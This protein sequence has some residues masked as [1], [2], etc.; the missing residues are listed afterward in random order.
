MKWST[1]FLFALALAVFGAVAAM[2]GRQSARTPEEYFRSVRDKVEAGQFDEE[3]AL[4]NLDLALERAEHAKDAHLASEVRLARAKVLTKIGSWDRAKADVESV[5]AER[6]NPRDIETLL[7]DLDARSGDVPKALAR[8]ESILSRAPD[9]LDAWARA[10]ALHTEAARAALTRALRVCDHGLVPHDAETAHAL[11]ERLGALDPTD[12]QRVV[13]GHHVRALF[14]AQQGEEVEQVLAACDEAARSSRAAREALAR[15]LENGVDPRAFALLVQLLDRAGHDEEAAS[16]VAVAQRHTAVR[17]DLECATTGLRTLSELERWRFASEISNGWLNRKALAPPEFFAMACR[18]LRKSER[19]SP[20]G[21]A[22][23]EL[24]EVADTG[25]VSWSD[26][27]MGLAYVKQSAIGR[28]L[29][30]QGRLMLVSRFLPSTDAEPE[31]GT[32]A[33]AYREAALASRF[34]GEANAEREYLKGA[35]DLDPDSDGELWLR[36]AELQYQSPNAGYRDPEARWARGMSLL[37]ARTAELLPRWREFGELELRGAGIDPYARRAEAASRDIWTPPTDASPYELYRMAEV[38]IE[39][40]DTPRATLL[41]RKLSESVPGFLP[42]IDMAIEL[43]RR[44]GRTRDLVEQCVRRVRAVGGTD[45]IAALLRPIPPG[46]LTS[47]EELALMRGD[48]ERFGRV[49][50]ARTLVAR[51]ERERARAILLELAPETMSFDARVLLAELHVELEDPRAA[52]EVLGA[53]GGKV[54]DDRSALQ[55]FVRAALRANDLDRLSR[56][57]EA[58]A[59]RGDSPRPVRLALADQLLLSGQRGFAQRLLEDLDAAPETRG[60]DVV[61]RLAL[62]ALLAKDE[63]GAAQYLERAQA[64]E[65]AGGVEL[66][67][68]LRAVD[69]ADWDRA[70][71]WSNALAESRFRATPL[72][73]TLIALLSDHLDEAATTI[74]EALA[75]E[76]RATNWRLAEAVL[77]ALKKESWDAPPY[78]GNTVLAETDRFLRGADGSADPRF[79]AAALLAS[80]TPVGGGWARVRVEATTK[81]ARGT[82]W[83][84][85]MLAQLARAQDDAARVREQLAL[86]LAQHPM[87]GPAWD[88]LERVEPP[89]SISPELA[90]AEVRQRRLAA[91]G[92]LSG[93][94][95]ERLLDEARARFAKGEDALALVRQAVELAPNSAAAQSELALRLASGPDVAGALAAQ[96]KAFAAFKAYSDRDALPRHLALLARAGELVT[97]AE[98]ATELEAL[99]AAHPHDPRAVAALAR[100]DLSRDPNNPSIGVARALARL[101]TFRAQHEDRALERLAPG[102]LAAFADLLLEI[103]PVE[104]RA[105]LEAELRLEPGSPE[106]WLASARALAAQGKIAEALDELRIV[107]RLAPAGGVQREMLRWMARREQKPER[108]NLTMQAVLQAEDRTEPDPEL[109]LLRAEAQWNFG[110][111]SAQ[112]VIDLLDTIDVAK[113]VEPGLAERHA[114]LLAA[115][116]CARGEPADLERARQTVAAWKDRVGDPYRRALLRTVAGLARPD[117]AQP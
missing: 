25:R 80:T 46:T 9:D 115:A 86:L 42:A 44:E 93:P 98:R 99:A 79:A 15:T 7:V 36:L 73:R 104:A 92:T 13:L 81:R 28:E 83:K 68:L 77:A 100:E 71:S 91:M 26:F 105:T 70:A 30:A 78:F 23:G 95:P 47:R 37:P 8:I 21:I 35:L 32:R 49:V 88:Q 20:L 111:R 75:K 50:V 10:G 27:Y 112:A 57:L 17:T 65:T 33:L 85:W 14:D 11:C 97:P 96:R 101:R 89:P 16:L 67:E 40:G 106:A 84:S 62:C 18:A 94:K 53:I 1:W 51:G 108:M 90:R 29:V 19:W 38:C 60:G 117:A 59:G 66:L 5:F 110:P 41:V 69:A 2:V 76:P 74:R 48:P 87:F 43:A 45:E 6:G 116:S 113:L 64:F 107:A 82:L 12:A 22:A 114:T 102:G 56:A 24:R 63:A 109:V 55:L 39:A 3:Q 34:L 61:M 52:L 54:F 58:F 72:Q 103:D 31:P 4:A